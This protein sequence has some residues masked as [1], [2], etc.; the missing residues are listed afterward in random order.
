ML[1]SAFRTAVAAACL[2]I[3]LGAAPAGAQDD[4]VLAVVNGE[5]IR[6]SELVEAKEQLGRQIP[7]VQQMPLEAILPGLLDRAINQR[8]ILAEA[9]KADL[10]DDPEVRAQLEQIKQEL[11][12][13]VYLERQVEE[14]LTD[15]RLKQAYEDFKT[16]NPPEDQVRARHILVEDEATAKEIIKKLDGGAAFEE[17]AKEESIGPSGPRGGDLGYFAKGAMVPE[18][19]EAAF[20]L[21]AGEVSK[22][23]VKTQFG[24]HVIKVEDRRKSEPPSFEEMEE[25]LRGQLAD[26]V[27]Q[28]VVSDLRDGAKVEM[29]LDAAAADK[30]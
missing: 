10:G 14:R 28:K 11:M 6:K 19:A 29:K 24:W 3:A 1:H 2:A 16:A 23:P 7:Q 4:P 26:E 5:E 9:K 20:A 30:Q 25:Q 21:K 8:L 22:A 18:F 13:R 15:D 27:A 12:Q 17:L